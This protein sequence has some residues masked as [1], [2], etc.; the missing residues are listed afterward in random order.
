M[1]DKTT[2]KRRTPPSPRHTF[3]VEGQL[4]GK[5]G[6]DKLEALKGRMHARTRSHRRGRR[7]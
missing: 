4:L 2:Q 3:S 1:S 6:Y 7:S 5:L